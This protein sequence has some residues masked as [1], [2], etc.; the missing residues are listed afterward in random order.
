MSLR[1]EFLCVILDRVL[2]NAQS[3][4]VEATI[5][6][7]SGVEQHLGIE[8]PLRQRGG[9]ERWTQADHAWIREHDAASTVQELE[10]QF[11]R[12][13]YQAIRRQAETLGTQTPTTRPTQAQGGELEHR[14]ACCAAGLCRRGM[15][16]AE[17]CVRL[18]GRSWD[19]IAS[20]G[21][22]L[23]FRLRRQAAYDRLVH[24]TREIIDT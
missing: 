15:S 7:R 14:G 11:S 4:A 3:D 10:A 20:Q 6:W 13:G 19:A 16:T 12:R 24:D 22:L 23:G 9:K 18:P 2:V 8:R 1:H 5:V 21:R 17:L